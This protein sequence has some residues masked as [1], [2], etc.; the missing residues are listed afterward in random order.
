M[1]ELK[2]IL[3]I[4][5]L[6]TGLS[7]FSQSSLNEIVKNYNSQTPIDFGELSLTS[8]QYNDLYFSYTYRYKSLKQEWDENA[9]FGAVM[10]QGSEILKSINKLTEFRTIRKSGK[11]IAY[12]YN[13][14]RGERIYGIIFKIKD[15]QYEVDVEHTFKI[16]NITAPKK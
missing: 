1:K 15:G 5:F 13:D 11:K 12:I 4:V 9:R 14:N 16:S 3:L 6:F 8:V 7:S 10:F 2:R